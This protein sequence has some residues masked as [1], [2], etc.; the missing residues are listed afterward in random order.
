MSNGKGLF[1]DGIPYSAEDMVAYLGNI[2][3]DGVLMNEDSLK[4]VSSGGLDVHIL[5]GT[6]YLKGFCYVLDDEGCDFT[7]EAGTRTDLIVLQLDLINKTLQL[8]LKQNQEEPLD[9]EIGIA[10]L[11]VDG[12]KVALTDIRKQAAFK[13]PLASKAA[14]I[15][16]GS[17]VGTGLYGSDNK[18]IITTD[19]ITPVLLIIAGNGYSGSSSYTKYGVAVCICGSTTVEWGYNEK[20]EFYSSVDGHSVSWYGNSAALQANTLNNQYKY[21]VIGI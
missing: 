13:L 1:F 12:E 2:C 5:G 3:S 8:V 7:A 4:P 20:F 16:M 19:G 14:K 11:A 18:N 15:E 17:Y 9:N 6:A 10:R 21:V